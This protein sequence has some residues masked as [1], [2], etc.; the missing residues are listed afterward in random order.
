MLVLMEDSYSDALGPWRYRRDCNIEK[1]Y[2]NGLTLEVIADRVD[3]S[4][5]TVNTRIR[6]MNLGERLCK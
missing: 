6:F 3:C 5:S 1:H 2:D 4:V